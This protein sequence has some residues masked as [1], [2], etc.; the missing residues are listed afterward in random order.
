MTRL[1]PKEKMLRSINEYDFTLSVMQIASACGWLVSHAWTS[2]STKY[3]AIYLSQ[4]GVKWDGLP[5]IIAVRER[6]V[7][8]ELKKRDS[9]PPLERLTPGQ[10]EWRERLLKLGCEYYVWQPGDEN[11]IRRVFQ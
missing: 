2:Q 3:T 8:A 7:W 10:A 6:V 4:H 9:K 1:D 11:E 5:D